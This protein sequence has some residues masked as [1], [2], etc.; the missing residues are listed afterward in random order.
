[1]GQKLR[2]Q[3]HL[4][5]LAPT[6]DRGLSVQRLLMDKRAVEHTIKGIMRYTACRT[7]WSVGNSNRDSELG[8]SN[9]TFTCGSQ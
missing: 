3:L 2:Y 5:R 1:M 6:P 9:I 7:A 8:S 4:S